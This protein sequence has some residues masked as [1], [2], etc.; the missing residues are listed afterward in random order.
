MYVCMYVCMYVLCM[1]EL[2]AVHVPVSVSAALQLREVLAEKPF[3]VCYGAVCVLLPVGQIQR[4]VP[5]NHGNSSVIVYLSMLLCGLQSLQMICCSIF[6]IQFSSEYLTSKLKEHIVE[7][8]T[9]LG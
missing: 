2:P 4:W 6:Q 8:L 7:P 5:P 1:V 9:Q 3:H